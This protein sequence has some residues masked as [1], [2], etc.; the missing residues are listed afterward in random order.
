MCGPSGAQSQ[1]QDEEMSFL[2]TQ[3]N[4]YSTAYGKFSDISDRLNAQFAPI[5][6]KGPNQE[7]FN[8]QEKTMLN[9]QATEGTANEYAKAKTALQEDLASEGGGG[10]STNL[11]SGHS[12]ELRQELLSGGAAEESREKQQ[13]LQADYTQGYNEYNSAVEGEEAV[14][15]GW[16][17]NSF[18][19]SE[20]GAA[21]TANNEAN[22][23]AAQQNTVWTSVLGALGGVAGQ[24]VG[25]LNVGPFG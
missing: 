9:T 17:P 3:Q 22:T 10:D 15:G 8:D 7:G 21:G 1:L 6:A 14:A 2:Q 12:D 23:I 13:I 19:A 11:T 24:V 16:N 20:E 18:A 4:A 25:N 5:I